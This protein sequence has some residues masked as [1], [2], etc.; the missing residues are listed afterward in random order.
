[1]K[2]AL[3]INLFNHFSEIT[4]DVEWNPW[5]EE[6]E[7]EG[8]ILQH[9][10]APQ[11]LWGAERPLAQRSPL[12]SADNA[13]AEDFVVEVWGKA[14]IGERRKNIVHPGP[15]CSCKMTS[16]LS[17]LLFLSFVRMESID[18]KL[19]LI[20]EERNDSCAVACN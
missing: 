5:G 19:S 7:E 6:F 10:V 1:M 2:H 18:N 11:I 15:Q 12:V 13:S 17:G 14:A 3:P 8:A 16:T 20:H 4:D 9:H